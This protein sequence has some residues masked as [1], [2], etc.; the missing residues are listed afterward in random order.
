[1]GS[2]KQQGSPRALWVFRCG[3]MP[4]LLS[5]KML[6]MFVAICRINM[7]LHIT[8]ICM[9]LPNQKLATS[10]VFLHAKCQI[11]ATGYRPKNTDSMDKLPG[12]KCLKN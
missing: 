2:Q 10:G 9:P 5:N 7:Q 6:T 12:S 11:S 4:A 1:M 3:P 8:V